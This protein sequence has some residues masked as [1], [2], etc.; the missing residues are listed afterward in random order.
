MRKVGIVGLDTS[1]SDAFASILGR[2]DDAEVTA[3]WDGNRVRNRAHLDRFCERYGATQY[4]SPVGMTGAVDGVMILT[5]DWDTHCELALPFLEDDVP[6]L[7]DKPI[8]GQLHDIEIIRD[9]AAGS[10]F[11]GGSAVPYHPAIESFSDDCLDHTL[12]SAGY[13]DPFYYG[14][15]LVDTVR[16]IVDADWTLVRPASDP[17]L[18]VDVVFEDDSFATLK[19][20]G[21]DDDSN[22][23]FLSVGDETEAAVVGS[24]DEERRVMYERY[25]ETYLDTIDGTTDERHRVF[26]GAKLLLATHASLSEQLSITPDS[27]QLRDVHIKGDSFVESYDPYY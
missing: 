5:V 10:P 1:H 18:S 6:T 25:I 23:A 26:D 24:D 13:E 14:C 22:F 12:Y 21:P 7:I 27:E 19:L 3:V 17:G 15:H 2:R 8:A 4:E 9:A 20:D 11:F 16:R